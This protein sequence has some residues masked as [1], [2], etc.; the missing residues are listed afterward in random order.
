[1]QTLENKL[2]NKKLIHG[3]WNNLQE[4]KGVS[5]DAREGA[6]ITK[7]KSNLYVFGGFSRELFNDLKVLCLESFKWRSVPKNKFWPK[8]RSQHTMDVYEGNLIL[9]GGSGPYLEN[10]P[11]RESYNDL[12]MFDTK[13][14]EWKNIDNSY[15][16]PSKRF[17]HVS[18]ILNGIMMI[19]G[20]VISEGR[21]V[22]DDFNVFDLCIK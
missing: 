11:F 21:V 16:P 18:G 12:L 9:F 17:S 13:L 3:F 2:F 5:P 7:I 1:M 4:V 15:F 6:T 8:V 22:L 14:Q 20:G 10:V 19:H